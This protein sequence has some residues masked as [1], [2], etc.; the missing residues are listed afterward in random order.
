[1]FEVVSHFWNSSFVTS[2]LR[3]S[4][5]QV[6][7]PHLNGGVQR[8]A[9]HQLLMPLDAILTTAAAGDAVNVEF[10]SPLATVAPSS[11]ELADVYTEL[12]GDGMC[13]GVTLQPSDDYAAASRAR[14]SASP[15]TH[16]SNDAELPDGGD[17]TAPRQID[18]VPTGSSAGSGEDAG[19]R[20][21]HFPASS[22]PP[23]AVPARDRHAAAS[24][25]SRDTADSQSGAT[26]RDTSSAV[27]LSPPLSPPL[28][29]PPLQPPPTHAAPPDPAQDKPTSRAQS[30]GEADAPAP[31]VAPAATAETALAAT[32]ETAL[33]ATPA[34][35]PTAESQNGSDGR[36]DSRVVTMGP[37]LLV[38][39]GAQPPIHTCC[40]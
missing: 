14:P 11:G 4:H 5:M 1:M 30:G 36:P 20:S 34:A 24:E 6:N 29:S 23:R 38:L 12:F 37:A 32:P 28:E 17:N 31:D 19:D 33:A 22:S 26:S 8:G 18:V 3:T 25:K 27:P 2:Q 9:P 35:A 39:P 7:T 16:S 13:A 10:R 15:A 21:W 40:T